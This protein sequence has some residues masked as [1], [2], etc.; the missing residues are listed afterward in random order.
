MPEDQQYETVSGF[1]CEAFGYI[2]RTGETIKVVLEKEN[3]EERD[4]V[5]SEPDRPDQNTKNQIFKLEI[6]AGNARKV[7]AVRFE[8]INQDG[9]TIESQGVVHPVPKLMKRKWG[10]NDESDG[11]DQ[12]GVPYEKDKTDTN[13][14]SDNFV[15]YENEDSHDHL[16]K[17][18]S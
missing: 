13:D 5:E 2:P 15:M 17:H 7:S 6:L 11:K 14:F 9:A 8:R 18:E 10:N 16:R 1:V 3:R 12:N 4:V